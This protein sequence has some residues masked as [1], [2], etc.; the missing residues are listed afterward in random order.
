[1][2]SEIFFKPNNEK[3]IFSITEMIKMT[4]SIVDATLKDN[5]I[6]VQSDIGENIEL[7]GLPNEFCQAV[8]NLIQNSKEALVEQNISDRL[9][10][11]CVFQQNGSVVITVQDNAGG[12]PPE[13]A[14]RLFD[15]YYTNKKDGSGIGLPMTKTIVEGHLGGTIVFCNKNGG[16]EFRITLPICP[17]EKSAED[18]S[19]CEIAKM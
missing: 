16:T 8:L 19:M 9:I 15:L 5:R 6:R 2:I 7:L 3:K 10:S 12:I 1:M 17:D 13:A 4:L 14:D 18:S 11:I